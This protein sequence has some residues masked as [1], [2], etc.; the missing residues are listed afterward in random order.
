MCDPKQPTVAERFA[1]TSD[2]KQEQFKKEL[3]GQVNQMLTRLQYFSY[4]K[5]S[6]KL[7]E[8]KFLHGPL[9][10]TVTLCQTKTKMRLW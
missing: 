4:C 1:H 10:N 2:V 3:E 8:R 5:S 9:K 7:H 6:K